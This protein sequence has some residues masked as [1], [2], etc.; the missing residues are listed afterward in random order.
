METLPI[1]KPIILNC[2]KDMVI[3]DMQIT[4]GRAMGHAWCFQNCGQN[5]VGV[6][7]VLVYESLYDVFADVKDKAL[8]QG[9]SFGHVRLADVDCG[10]M[11]SGRAVD[12]VW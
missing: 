6:E 1:L 2:G 7:R 9:I 10:S 5:C 4:G 12:M 11:V 8:R 3:M